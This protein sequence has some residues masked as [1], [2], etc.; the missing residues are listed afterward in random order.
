MPLVLTVIGLSWCYYIASTRESQLLSGYHQK[1]DWFWLWW[2]S[3]VSLNQ[4]EADKSL[5]GTGNSLAIASYLEKCF[6]AFSE[7]PK[8]VLVT[9]FS[10]VKAI[11]CLCSGKHCVMKYDDGIALIIR[12]RHLICDVYHTVNPQYPWIYSL[13]K[14][15][16]WSSPNIMKTP[17]VFLDSWYYQKYIRTGVMDIWFKIFTN[18]VPYFVIWLFRVFFQEYQASELL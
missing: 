14:K 3:L 5:L 9:L 12:R 1:S 11:L 7:F 4:Y 2:Q 18:V 17:V 15:Y 13:S 8:W 6:N 10:R 16:L